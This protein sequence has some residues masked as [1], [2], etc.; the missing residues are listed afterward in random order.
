VL[1]TLVPRIRFHLRMQVGV[2]GQDVFLPRLGCWKVGCLRN[3][4]NLT[5]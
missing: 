5:D 4:P 1:F 2:A 3:F